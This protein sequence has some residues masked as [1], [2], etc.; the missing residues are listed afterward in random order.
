MHYYFVEW[1]Q[2]DLWLTYCLMASIGYSISRTRNALQKLEF[3]SY[4]FCTG[5][6]FALFVNNF[7][8]K[9]SHCWSKCSQIVCK[10]TGRRSFSKLFA[11]W[12][13]Y[14]SFAVCLW[15]L[16]EVVLPA[17]P[18]KTGSHEGSLI[19]S[20]QNQLGLTQLNWVWSRADDN[21]QDLIWK[22]SY[23]TV[24]QQVCESCTSSWR[25][26]MHSECEVS[27]QHL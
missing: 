26:M 7:S 15:P 16:S 1:V 12:K 9:S 18:T 27:A 2:R 20:R 23:C 22:C 13:H 8:P 25:T 4:L 21:I 14:C 19:Y 10:A 3:S 11:S 24:Q 6:N 17:L 5:P